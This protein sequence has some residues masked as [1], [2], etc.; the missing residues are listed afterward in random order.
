VSAANVPACECTSSVCLMCVGD[1]IVFA[2]GQQPNQ[3]V[4]VGSNFLQAKFTVAAAWSSTRYLFSQLW[5]D[6][7]QH[8]CVMWWAELIV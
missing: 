3:R 4:N 8:P 7:Y 2:G 6:W 1:M 5:Y